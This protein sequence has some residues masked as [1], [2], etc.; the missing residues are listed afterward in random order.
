MFFSGKYFHLLWARVCVCSRFFDHCP[1]AFGKHFKYLFTFL[2]LVFIWL[3][4]HFPQFS[5]CH[6]FFFIFISVSATFLWFL[7]EKLSRDF[8]CEFQRFIWFRFCSELFQF[9]PADQ[10][11][12]GTTRGHFNCSYMLKFF[13]L[14]YFIYCIFFFFLLFLF[15]YLYCCCCSLAAFYLII[16]NSNYIFILYAHS[17]TKNCCGSLITV[18]RERERDRERSRGVAAACHANDKR[19]FHWPCWRFA[20]RLI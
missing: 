20:C 11:G 1:T 18:C 14:V 7:C 13:N 12:W 2:P 19:I 3:L 16:K 6:C 15:A 9:S 8:V 4:Y 17:A 5:F 10:E